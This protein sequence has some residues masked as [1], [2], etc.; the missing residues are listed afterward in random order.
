MLH[1]DITGQH[2]HVEVNILQ[3]NIMLSYKYITKS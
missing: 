3:N 2:E 1:I